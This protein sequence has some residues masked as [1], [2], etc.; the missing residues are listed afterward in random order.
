M[1]PGIHPNYVDAT[2]TCSCGNTW[3]T[4]STKSAIRTDLC[5]QCHPFFTGEQRI[6]DTAGQVERFMNKLNSAQEGGATS[7][8][9]VR[10]EQKM[11]ETQRARTFTPELE[12]LAQAGDAPAE[13]VRPTA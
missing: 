5:S 4:R 10:R 3:T 12:A 1:K 9:Q 7:K 2:V 13:A 11:T 8:K 6:V